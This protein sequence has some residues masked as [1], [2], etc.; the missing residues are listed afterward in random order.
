MWAFLIHDKRTGKVVGSRDRFGIKPLFCHRIHDGWLFASEIKAIRASGLYRT[1]P[2][3][4]VIAQ[5]L[6]RG[7][8]DESDENLLCGNQEH[9]TGNV[10]RD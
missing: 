8:L 4:S 1:E 9:P 2:N 10:V 6:I 7:R 5:Y 3:W